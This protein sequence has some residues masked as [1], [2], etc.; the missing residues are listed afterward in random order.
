MVLRRDADGLHE[1]HRL[2]DPVGKQPVALGLR[3]ILD[4][5]EHP[6]VHVVEIG[7]AALGEG[8]QQV[9]RRRRLPVGHDLP[10]GVRHAR[11]FGE[12]Y[13]VDD[14]AAVARQLHVALPL[15]AGRARLGELAGDAADLDDRQLG[16]ERQDDGHLQEGAE[17]I[18]DV[19]GAVLGEALGAVAALQEEAVALGDHRQPALQPARL[20]GE[21]QR[22]KARQPLLGD[23]ER[24]LVRIVRHLHDRLLPP[25]VRCPVLCHHASTCRSRRLRGRRSRA[26]GCPSAMRGLIAPLRP[27]ANPISVRRTEPARRSGSDALCRKCRALPEARR[28]ARRS[29]GDRT[30]ARGIER[31]VAVGQHRNVEAAGPEDEIAKARLAVLDQEALQDGIEIGLIDRAGAGMAGHVRHAPRRRRAGCRPADR[32]A[33]ASTRGA[34]AAGARSAAPG[35]RRPAGCRPC[36]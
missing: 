8:A 25:A 29:A 12:L 5:T 30:T 36:R 4:E 17:E 27:H 24:V 6:L 15:D 9:E 1:V 23:R 10:L 20:A 3:R 13:A 28:R 18:A 33:S 16:A 19:V 22:R 26:F 7:I 2:G 21:D 14:V 35:G 11:L 31:R 32:P 34:R